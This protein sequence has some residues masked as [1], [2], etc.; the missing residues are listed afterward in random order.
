MLLTWTR[1]LEAM[2]AFLTG[3]QSLFVAIFPAIGGQRIVARSD[4]LLVTAPAS[5]AADT[6]A[7][8]FTVVSIHYKHGK[9]QFS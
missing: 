3:S 7:G 6:P 4:S 8:P 2:R 1:S 5:L 9:L